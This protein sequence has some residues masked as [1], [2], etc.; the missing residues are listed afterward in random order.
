MN[1]TRLDI[2]PTSYGQRIAL[3]NRDLGEASVF[4]WIAIAVGAIGTVLMLAWIAFPAS[5]GIEIVRKG[6]WFGLLFVGFGMLGLRGLS[7]TLKLLTAG[8]AMVRNRFGCEVRVTDS[9]IIS[10][11]KFG[12]FSH[13]RKFDRDKIESLYLRSMVINEDE[14]NVPTIQIDWITKRVPDDLHGIGTKR[15]ERKVIAP[16]YPPA[17]L[18]PLAEVL[19]SELNRNRVGLVSIVQEENDPGET[20]KIEQP[21]AIVEQP[22]EKTEAVPIERPSDSVIEV[23][24]QSD[25]KVYRVPQRGVW[26]GSHG[27]MFFALIWN[28]FLALFTIGMLA[29]GGKAGQDLWIIILMLSIFWAVG[30]GM[31]VGA[32]YLGRQSALIGVRDGLLFIERKTIFGTKWTDFEPGNIASVHIGAGNLEVNDVPVKEL[33]IQPV[34][35]D[36]IGMF[37]QLDDDEIGWLAQQLSTEL[38]LKP[39]SFGSWQR[40]L[41]PGEPL[42][43]PETSQVTVDQS[44]NETVIT[45]P[46]QN[47]EGHWMLLVM[48]VAFS[49]GA[50]PAAIIGVWKFETSFIVIPIAIIGTLTGMTMLVAERLYSSRWFRLEVNPSQITIERYGFLSERVATIRRE[51]VRAVELKESGA[52]VNGRI[53]MRLAIKSSKPSESFTLMAGRDER[54]IA[55][56]AALI[57]QQMRL[58]EEPNENSPTAES[59]PV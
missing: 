23:I 45:I 4:G 27:L 49:F 48:G 16:G 38:D 35:E 13:S 31:V 3:P 8:I 43:P 33:K 29:G 9:E 54:E 6:D 11:D 32:F 28:G 30:I 56:V 50:L 40:F 37:S 24:D 53:Y 20:T 44:A 55:Y 10:R 12:W 2:Q 18:L 41:K 21:I 1:T 59:E 58:T 5:V 34:G 19:K 7:T 57:D 42:A 14:D 25:A 17:I 52:R 51:N 46:K 47:L 22:A 15:G 26:K 36:A 39:Q